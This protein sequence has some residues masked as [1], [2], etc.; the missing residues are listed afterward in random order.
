M[1][2]FY[3]SSGFH[4]IV[5][6]FCP[7]KVNVVAHDLAKFSVNSNYSCNWGDA[8]RSFILSGVANN[9]SIFNN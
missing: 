4:K 5:F 8:P 1:R 9:V 6:K 3:Y 7:T 2:I